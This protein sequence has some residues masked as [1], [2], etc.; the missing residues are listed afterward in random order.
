MNLFAQFRHYLCLKGFFTSSVRNI[1]LT[2]IPRSGTTLSCHILDQLENTIALMEPLDL[3]PLIGCKG[4]EERLDFLDA[5]FLKIRKQIHIDGIVTRKGL[6]GSPTNTFTDM[7]SSTVKR[8]SAIK[9]NFEEDIIKELGED[10]TLV[11]KH[12]NAFS[13]LLPELV[14]RFRCF[15][16]IRNP[17]SVLASWSSLDH[18]LAEGY[19]PMAEAFDPQLKQA[20]SNVSDSFTRQLEL[21]NWYYRI[22]LQYLPKTNILRYEDIIFSSG[23]NLAP[24]VPGVG[25]ISYRLQSKNHNALYDPEVMRKGLESL[26]N[27]PDHYCWKFYREPE[28]PG[29]V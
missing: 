10:F 5:S 2:G 17:L 18:P 26:L 21:L 6:I 27:E 22:Y 12:P 25:E 16:I 9:E 28:L 7:G 15:A 3:E 23:A 19:A 20:L 4:P 13:A 8:V 1:I 29:V 11:I 14:T 24:I